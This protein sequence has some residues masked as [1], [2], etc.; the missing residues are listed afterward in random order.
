MAEGRAEGE[1]PGREGM[2]GNKKKKHES[3]RVVRGGPWRRGC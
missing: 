3:S 2:E 1:L